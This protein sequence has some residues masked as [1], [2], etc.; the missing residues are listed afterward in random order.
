MF[1]CCFLHDV[2]YILCGK[3]FKNIQALNEIRTYDLCVT[4]AM[5]SR[6]RP[7]SS[8]A[9]AAFASIIMS[10]FNCYCYNYGRFSC[11]FE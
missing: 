10:T 8:N 4:S 3:E 1:A 2:S 7:F 9:M 11:S 5:L 6:L